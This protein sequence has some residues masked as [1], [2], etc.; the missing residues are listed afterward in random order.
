M[1]FKVSAF[2][3]PVSDTVNALVVGLKVIYEGR[4]DPLLRLAEY[5]IVWVIST[6]GQSG[7]IVAYS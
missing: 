4:T 1:S 2:K 3:T 7:L 5:L 6:V